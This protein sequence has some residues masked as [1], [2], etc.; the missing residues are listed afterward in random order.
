MGEKPIELSNDIAWADIEMSSV[1]DDTQNIEHIFVTVKCG[2]IINLRFHIGA[3]FAIRLVELL[4]TGR[5][6][7]RMQMAPSVFTNA[8]L[9]KKGRCV[10]FDAETFGMIEPNRAIREE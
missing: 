9:F 1:Y 6:R 2:P 5:T 4:R 7:V 10:V 8:R 3:E